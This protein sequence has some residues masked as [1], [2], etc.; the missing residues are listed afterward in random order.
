VETKIGGKG[1]TILSI[2]ATV[3]LV[4]VVTLI[5]AKRIDISNSTTTIAVA[6]IANTIG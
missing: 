3:V 4:I 5:D 2:T 1:E 6:T